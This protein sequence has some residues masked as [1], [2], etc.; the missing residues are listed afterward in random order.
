MGFPAQLDKNDPAFPHDDTVSHFAAKE[1]LIL[2]RISVALGI[3]A[4]AVTMATFW[5][6]AWVP[7]VI[8]LVCFAALLLCHNVEQRTRREKFEQ[9]L[10]VWREREAELRMTQLADPAAPPEAGHSPDEAAPTSELDIVPMP[11]LKREMWMGV[12]IVVGLGLAAVGVVIAGLVTGH[13]ERDLVLLATGLFVVYGAF[14]MGPVW[15]GWFGDVD[16]AERRKEQPERTPVA[17]AQFR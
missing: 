17:R 3:A 15:L 9:E 7:A 16:E 1:L 5:F 11:V 12:E 13:L 6:W 8:L 10:A 2:L 14:V 4:T